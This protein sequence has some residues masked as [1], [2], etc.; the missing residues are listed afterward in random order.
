MGVI[1]DLTGQRFGRLQAVEFSH[2]H[3][4][5]AYW[6]CVCDCGTSKAIIGFSL[7]NGTIKSCGCIRKEHNALG[8]NF[9]HGMS[10]SLTY[11]TYHGMIKRCENVNNKDY[12]D[13]GG[14]GITVCK[15]WKD[16]FENFLADMGERPKGMSLGRIDNNGGYNPVNCSWQTS[17]E[18][19]NNSRSNIRITINNITKTVSE[20]S[21]IV[22]ISAKTI[23]TRLYGGWDPEEAVITPPLE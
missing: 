9:K 17:L 15:R 10:K 8:R 5:N 18:Q 21:K 14:R 11:K 6:I 3:R 13:Y 7:T 20:W 12:P 1:K 22:G 2:L 16:S 4:H 19:A 23:Y